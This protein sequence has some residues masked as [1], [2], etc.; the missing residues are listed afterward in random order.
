MSCTGGCANGCTTGC[1]TS[2]SLSCSATCENN[3]IGSCNNGCTANCIDTCATECS[4]CSSCSG[5]CR[6]SCSGCSGCSSCSGTCRGSC[7]GCSGC[8]SCSGTCSGDCNNACKST[9]APQTIANLASNIKAGN[10][11]KVND[12]KRLRDAIH[13]ELSRRNKTIPSDSYVVEPAVNSKILVEH[14]QKVFDDIKVM[15]STKFKT[16]DNTT[17]IK[18]ST[19]TD[20]ITYIQTL[21]NQNIKN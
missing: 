9:E 13:N 10:P 6:G 2:C 5:T 3:C 18:A 4:G 14:S 12:F 1:G 15:D 7:S 20:A 17:I 21:M 8:S 19:Y 16:I 11:I